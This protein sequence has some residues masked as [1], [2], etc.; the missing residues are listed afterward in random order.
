MIECYG[1]N[2]K[3]RIKK[4]NIDN[5]PKKSLTWIRLYSPEKEELETV[6]EIS[7]IPLK[8]L[9]ESSEEEER[10]RLT[11]KRYLEI[12]YS[13]PHYYRD[14]GL[15]T[16]EIY[17]YISKNL[18]ITIA[19]EKSKILDKIEKKFSKNLGKFMLKSHGKFLFYALDSINDDFLFIIDKIAANIE[20][21]KTKDLSQVNLADLYSKSITSAYFNQSI[22]AN[23]EVLNQLRK[24]HYKNFANEDRQ[25]F[26][27]L[28]YDKL[29]ILD[30]EKIQRQLI[31]NLIDIQSISSTEKLNVTIKRLTSL[32][33]LIATPTLISSIYGMNINL[34][35]QNHP[36]AFWILAIF[37]SIPTIMLWM[38]MKKND[39][40]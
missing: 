36:N 13:A 9:I 23:V 7:N 3:N 18:M 22:L 1:I 16:Q 27:E 15:Q 2:G 33:L 35:F 38:L 6:S 4:L 10:P 21:L 32:A 12:I 20:T 25:N 29:Q 5:L 14:E 39:W 24:S 31:M 37:M 19:K 8:E 28:Y 17:F 34:P 26:S 30:T 11:K 40:I